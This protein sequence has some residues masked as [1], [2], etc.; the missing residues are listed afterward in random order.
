MTGGL[1]RQFVA[2]CAKPKQATTRDVA[3]VAVVPKLLP[4][5]RVAQVNF[6][7]RNLNREKRIA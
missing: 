2:V 5:K 1:Q 4:G 3:E 7:K 6:D